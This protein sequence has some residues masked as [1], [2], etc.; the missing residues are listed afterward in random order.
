MEIKFTLSLCQR[1]LK[2]VFAIVYA[3]VVEL[4]VSFWWP[5]SIFEE[6]QSS[7]YDPFENEN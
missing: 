7:P 6:D 2:I 4:P 5:K 3:R 1:D